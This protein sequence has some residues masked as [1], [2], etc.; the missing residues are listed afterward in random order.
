[1]RG[2]LWLFLVG[3]L[4]VATERGA[5]SLLIHLTVEEMAEKSSAV[6]LGRCVAVKSELDP[7]EFGMVT[8]NVFEVQEYYKGNLGR[9]VVISEPGGEVGGRVTHY[10]GTPQF[11]PGDELVLFV[12]A[13]PSGRHQVIGLTQGA[14]WAARDPQTGEIM[15]TQHAPMARMIEPRSHTHRASTGPVSL[16]LS[17]LRE[18]RPFRE[19]RVQGLRSGGDR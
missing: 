11:Q 7:G 19:A 16:T 12:W 13:G 8:N 4:L 14:F 18:L 1:M 9:R 6:F 3:L 10:P 15:L 2:K 5:A 17:S